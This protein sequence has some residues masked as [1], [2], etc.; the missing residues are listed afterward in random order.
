MEI[1]KF[2]QNPYKS[3]FGNEKQGKK[4][5]RS[6]ISK[7]NGKKKF[8]FISESVLRLKTVVVLDISKTR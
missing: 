1:T 2:R 7:E 3:R 8:M 4:T 6:E 5:I